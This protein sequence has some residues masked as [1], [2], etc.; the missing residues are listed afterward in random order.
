M[1]LPR[2]TGAGTSAAP[3]PRAYQGKS[4]RFSVLFPFPDRYSWDRRQQ[5]KIQ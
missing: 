2:G 3:I 4:L 5:E 1:P